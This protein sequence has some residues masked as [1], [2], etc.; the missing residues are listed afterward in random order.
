ML[1][2]KQ[3]KKRQRRTSKIV[4]FRLTCGSC[5]CRFGVEAGDNWRTIREETNSQ[6]GDSLYSIRCPNCTKDVVFE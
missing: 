4:L 6:E 3:G 5:G 2:Y 1:V